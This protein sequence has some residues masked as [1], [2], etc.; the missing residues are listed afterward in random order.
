[1]RVPWIIWA[2]LLIKALPAIAM[3]GLML[4]VFSDIAWGFIARY[5][6]LLLGQG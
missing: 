4:L 1:M 2:W 6:E 5:A 3:G